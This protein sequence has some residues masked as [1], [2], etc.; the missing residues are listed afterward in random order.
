MSVIAVPVSTAND[1]RDK[2]HPVV[3]ASGSRGTAHIRG[4]TLISADLETDS[5]EIPAQTVFK[6]GH[7]VGARSVAGCFRTSL[8][9]DI[10][11]PKLVYLQQL[12]Q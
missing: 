1:V 3:R 5:V 8:R 10:F 2:H 4:E 6:P 11:H 12:L 7:A 9:P